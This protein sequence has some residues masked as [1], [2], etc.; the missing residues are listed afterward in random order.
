MQQRDILGLG[1]MLALLAGLGL[2]FAYAPKTST[3]QNTFL[4]VEITGSSVTVGTQAGE[5]ALRVSA[6]IVQPGFVTV[7]Q[8]LGQAPGPVV[9]Q[10]PLLSVG[11]HLNLVVTTTELLLPGSQYFVLLFVDDGDGIYQAGVDLPV[12]SDGQVIKQTFSL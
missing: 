11:R 6:E 12:M 10:S 2:F 4:P 8:A 9:G 5:Q 7:H 3:N 1:I